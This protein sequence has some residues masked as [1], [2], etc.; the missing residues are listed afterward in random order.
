MDAYRI[1]TRVADDLADPDGDAGRD[2]ATTIERLN[3]LIA[4]PLAFAGLANEDITQTHGWRFLELGRRI[5]RAFQTAELLASTLVHSIASER[6]LLEAVLRGADSLM[7]Y[8]VRYL[9]SLQPAAAIDLLITDETNPRS[10]AFQLYRIDE[11]IGQ[12]PTD[13][14]EV[15]LG[16]DEK[17][18]KGLLNHAQMSDPV[19]LSRLSDGG[20]AR[21]FESVVAIID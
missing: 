8:R 13:D 15:G 9:L 18:A 20:F 17:L 6:Q 4:G 5:E 10:I 16:E 7:T 1:L 19:E 3:R 11:M 12:L 21:R 14:S 2:I